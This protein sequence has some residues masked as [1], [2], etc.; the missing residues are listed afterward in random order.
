MRT[1]TS[2]PQATAVP[3]KPRK[4]KV[5]T[6]LKVVRTERLA[7]HMVRVVLGGEQFDA[8]EF[9][10][11]TDQYIKLLFADP[12]LGLER[13]YDMEALREQLPKAQMP[14]R[15]TYTIRHI[16]WKHK[17]IWVDFVV[18][19]DEGVAGPWAANAQP[20]DPISFFGPGSGYAPRQEADFHVIAGDESA[21]PAIAAALEGMDADARGV[22]VLEVRD[23]TEEVPLT[24]PEGI[25]LRWIHRGGDFTPEST[26]ITDH[27]RNIEIPDGDVQVFVHGEREQMK[28]IR[29]LLV[30]ERGL[31][32]KGMSLSAYWAYGRIEDQFQAEK[33]TPVG[34]I[35][36]EN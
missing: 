35:D 21:I 10:E 24:V 8:M 34:N 17:Q 18:H 3:K 20:G 2:S 15:R 29:K 28:R 33:Q 27:L 5:Q 25:D 23:A 13:P 19:G 16:D 36:P 1:Q 7:P 31:E 11:D 6:L 22:V 14:V 26:R 12:A 4:T 9:K 32:R 30:K